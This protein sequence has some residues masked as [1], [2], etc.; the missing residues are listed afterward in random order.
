MLRR[1]SRVA[2]GLLV[3]SSMFMSPAAYAWWSD[4]WAFRK[5][6]TLDLSPAGANIP[7]NATNVPVLVRLSIANFPYFGDAR[8]DGADLRFVAGDDKTPLKFH[9]EK[10]DPQAQIALLW[11]NLPQVSGGLNADRIYLYYGNPQAASD[12]D[13]AGTYDNRQALV[14]HFAGG[15]TQDSSAS[16]NEPQALTAQLNAA[17]LI[18]SGLTFDGTKSFT[19]PASPSLQIAPDQGYTISAWVKADGAQT[20]AVIAALGDQGR[21]LVLGID[22]ERAFARLRDGREVLVSQAQGTLVGE[23]HHL[24]LRA[25]ATSL[26]LFVDGVTAGKADISL[27]ALGGPLTV[28]GGAAGG[29]LRG[30]LDELQ[31]AGAARSDAWLRAAALSQG[32]VAPLLVYGGDAQ[33]DQGGAETSY[34]ASTLRN[35]TVDGWVII[36]VLAVMFLASVAIMAGKLLYLNRV[37]SGNRKF[38]EEFHRQRN[39][40]AALERREA[41][42][43]PGS[44][45]ESAFEEQKGSGVMSALHAKDKTYGISVLWPLYHHGMREVMGRLDG[46]AAGA[47]RVKSLSPQSIEAIRATMDATLTRSTQR[48][49]SQMVWLTISI[50]GG[51]FLGL[52]GTVVGV[53]ITF[54][55][56]AASGEVNVNAIA[57]GTAAALVATVAGLAVAI[58]CLFG[59]NYL[60][61]RIKEIVADMRVFVDEFTTRIAETYT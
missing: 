11:V 55:A 3:L 30:D 58:P 10:F 35:V 19:V 12:G 34:F 1:V 57:P 14:Y 13:A 2:C 59:Y 25:S 49:Q 44:E 56:I 53:M 37:A 43:H 52:L 36:A 28:G 50:S 4:D 41:K 38:L 23:W 46:K 16:R 33:N 26:E 5:E 22:G 17:S 51:P 7:A 32:M 20:R 48:L 18:G 15:A 39:D 47:D 42:A 21:D 24:A 60:N 61:T 8:P 54:A 27:P 45:D 6:L 31:V 40:P 29:F 9:I